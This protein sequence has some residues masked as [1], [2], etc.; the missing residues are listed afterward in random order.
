MAGGP[1]VGGGGAEGG[2]DCPL[3]EPGS[4]VPSLLLPQ[5]TSAKIIASARSNVSIFFIFVPSFHVVFTVVAILSML[6]Y[7]INYSQ[8][9]RFQAVIYATFA[10]IRCIL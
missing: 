1:P 5:A 9:N 8:S 10:T 4:V 3:S 6:F 2:R 7:V